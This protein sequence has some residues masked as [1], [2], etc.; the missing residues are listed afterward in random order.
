[1]G[2]SLGYVGLRY[3]SNRAEGES[4]TYAFNRPTTIEKMVSPN[5]THRN[6]N[7]RTQNGTSTRLSHGE[8]SLSFSP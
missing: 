8:D 2:Q 4:K 6:D 3:R 7:W 5:K 1:M